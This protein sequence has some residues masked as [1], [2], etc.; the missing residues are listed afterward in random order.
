MGMSTVRAA[1]AISFASMSMRAIL[2]AALKR[3]GAA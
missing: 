1:V 2:A 3:G